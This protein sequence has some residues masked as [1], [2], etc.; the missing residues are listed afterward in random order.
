M[1]DVATQLRRPT[2]H[3]I[4][5]VP[6]SE[7]ERIPDADEILEVQLIARELEREVRRGAALLDWAWA[8]RRAAEAAAYARAFRDGV[9]ATSRRRASTSPTPPRCCSRC[10]APRPRSSSGACRIPASR[11]LLAL[12]TWKHGVVAS[13]AERARRTLPRLDGRRVVLAA[14]EVHDVVRDALARE[15]P[16]AGCQVI[17]LPSSVSPAQVARVAADEDAD[18]VVVATYNGGAL[19]LGARA[20]AGARGRRRGAGRSSAACSTRTTAA[21]CPST[22]APAWT[23]SASAASTRSRS[24]ARRSPRIVAM[25]YLALIYGNKEIWNNWPDRP[26]VIAEVDAFNQRLTESGE[27]ITAN[28][29]IGPPVSVR[30]SGDSPVVS[31][32]PYLEVKEHVGS[33][34]ILDVESHE[35]ALEIVQE[36]PGVTSGGGGVE[37]WRLMHQR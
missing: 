4:N 1:I 36:Y 11:E 5:P 30:Q 16:Q 24:S 32:G 18:A 37:L 7:A 29:L 21:R 33:Y 23:R 25:R 8:E 6:L 17:V 20:H 22:P 26:A 14:L 3:A 34:F 2:G 35:R 13:V 12:E 28:G 9:L 15:L 10:G 27:L 19:T 31:D